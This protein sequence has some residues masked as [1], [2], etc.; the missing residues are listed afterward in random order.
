[1]Y[2]G[3]LLHKRYVTHQKKR[4][5][6]FGFLRH[7]VLL[8]QRYG[9]RVTLQETVHFDAKFELYDNFFKLS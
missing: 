6:F 7:D 8:L 2:K 9:L 4:I 3:G 5:F 1:M